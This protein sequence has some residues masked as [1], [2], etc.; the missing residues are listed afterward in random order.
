M[1]E[2]TAF[3]GV[4]LFFEVLGEGEIP[5]LFICGWGTPTGIKNW[6]PE[7]Q[8]SEKYKLILIDLPGH[9]KSGRNREIC[10]MQSYGEDVKSVVEYLDL[11]NVILIGHS[12]GAA[13]MLEAETLISDRIL[14][15]IAVDSLFP[16]IG[17]IYRKLEGP[18]MEKFVQPFRD[19]FEPAYEYF[20]SSF[21]PE[22]FDK[23]LVQ[24]IFD[25]IPTLDQRSLVSAWIELCKWDVLDILPK[26][27]KPIKCIVAGRTIKNY[28]K[29]EYDRVF[30][31]VIYLDGLGH[32][33]MIEDAARLNNA[34]EEAIQK[35]LNT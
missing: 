3:D 21:L 33:I 17:S 4:K 6:Q 26:V 32:L 12:M 13:V 16:T 1:T 9:G 34:L 19:N 11:H 15:L 2:I 10:S 31:S 8:L 7:L 22:N 18:Y 25:A 20:V 24:W 30:D 14:G 23:S 5:L 28:S 27:Q 35:L 29:E